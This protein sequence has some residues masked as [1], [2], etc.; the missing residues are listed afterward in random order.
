MI[1]FSGKRKKGEWLLAL[2]ILACIFCIGYKK[3]LQ[4]P[5]Q[6]L[7][8]GG[9]GLKNYYTFMY[10]VA[11]DSTFMTFEGMNYPFGENI[12]FTDN[13]PLLSNTTKIV[14]TI[15]PSILCYLPSVHNLSLLIGII[16]GALGLFLA[17]RQRKIDF[18]FAIICTAGLMLMHP[19]LDRIHGHF[20]MVYPVLPWLLLLWLKIWDENKT[21]LYSTAIGGIILCTGL[22]H[23]YFFITGGIMCCLALML[24][25]LEGGRKFT[26][27]QILKMSTL[28]VIVPFVILQFFASYFNHAGD[29][30]SSPYGFFSYHGYWEGLMFSYK[31]PLFEFINSNILKVRTFDDEGKSYM[32]IASVV[33][34]LV[35]IFMLLFQF[36]KTKTFLNVNNTSGKL[37]W[38]FILSAFICFGFPFTING[39]QWLLDYTGPFKQFRSIGRV[40]WVAF[41]AIN[42]VS[43]PLIYHWLK[44]QEHWGVKRQILYFVIPIIILLEGNAFFRHKP[45]N[46]TPIEAF[47]CNNSFKDIPV[48]G[49]DYQALLPDP[50]FSIGSECFSWWDQGYNVNQSFELG[51]NLHLPTMGANM[52]RTSFAQSIMLNELICQPFKVPDIIQVLRDIDKRPLLV[53][54]TKLNIHEPRAKLTHWTRDAPIV[55]ENDQFRLRRL[56][57]SDFDSIVSRYNIDMDA[58][59]PIPTK[60]IPLTF[61][62]VEGQSGWGY[63]AYLEV[64]ST[65]IG[66]QVISYWLECTDPTRV[67]AITEAWQFDANHGTVNYIGE[68]NRFN[69]KK[70]NGNK[71]Q[72]EIPINIAVNTHKIV[73]RISKD[74]QKESEELKISDVLL[75][76][77]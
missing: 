14:A 57:L 47:Y 68:A 7:V 15:F 50:Y 22:L 16:F 77:K 9:D 49:E 76:I 71:L 11:Y 24:S 12:I 2:L 34:T 67:S 74:K 58:A 60:E 31:L 65:M 44:A 4:H 73:I 45:I 66:Q 20:A 63:E 53:V 48:N 39:M 51:Y 72:I 8:A 3:I 26:F 30:P 75:K 64:D 1:L 59:T 62:K 46:Q 69:Y 40:G 25:L 55:Y 5:N 61:T 28:Q 21:I 17:F 6:F 38:I 37:I 13:Q 29:R 43:I 32:G 27:I 56:E 18:T 33:F 36:G 10:H 23:M 54:E 35:G 52:S 41:Y 19:Q 42:L 70:Y